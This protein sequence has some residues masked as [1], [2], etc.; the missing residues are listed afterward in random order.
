MINIIKSAL[1]IACFQS[2]ISAGSV[3]GLFN[4]DSLTDTI[5]FGEIP[6]TDG[7]I[8]VEIICANAEGNPAHFTTK[9][10]VSE[11]NI[12][13]LPGERGQIV[14]LEHGSTGNSERYYGYYSFNSRIND[15]F[16][17]KSITHTN[18]IV[19]DGSFSAQVVIEYHSGVERIDGTLVDSAAAETETAQVRAARLKESLKTLG[20]QLADFSKNGRLKDMPQSALDVKVYAEMILNVPVTEAT[21][22]LY[23]DIAYYIGQMRDG[24]YCSVYI[25][26]RV[27]EKFPERA[28]AHLNIADAY[29][30]LEIRKQAGSAY[31]KYA[32]L[33]KKQGKAEK[34]PARVAKRAG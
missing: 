26:S 27:I 11:E 4:A 10:L 14:I 19:A 25:L 13:F 18:N 28:V 21:V 24:L 8:P 9:Y 34:I 30:E 31:A 2:L 32:E 23:N 5:R 22:S 33:M 6:G 12:A 17:V 15:W 20:E 3:T 29:W 7:L 1:L 16:L